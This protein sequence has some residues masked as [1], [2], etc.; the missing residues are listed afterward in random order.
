MLSSIVFYSGLVVLVIGVASLPRPLRFAGI[1]TRA[2]AAAVACAG[3]VMIGAALLWPL[4]GVQS[5][6]GRL[7]IDEFMPVWQ[8]SERHE[9]HVEASPDRVFDAIRNVRSGE[10]AL[11]QTLT[12][13]RRFGRSGPESILNAPPEKPILEVATHSGFMVL[14]DDAP[15]ELV[16]GLVTAAPGDARK[17]GRLT[18]GLFRQRL[19]PGV[20]LATMNFLVMPD[21]RGGS[22]L[23][24]ETR[25]YVNDERTLR[26]FTIYWCIIHPG[27]DIIRRMWLRAIR[28]RAER[29]GG[30]DRRSR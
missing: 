15:R 30:M 24:T 21:G 4:P 12:A 10:I 11:F 1:R 7:Y 17:G 8:V 19:R 22:N 6:S 2:V 25:V 20:G 9:I 16:M 27:S 28:T 29:E 18:P 26:A 3:I 23:S 5:A 13:I 14:A